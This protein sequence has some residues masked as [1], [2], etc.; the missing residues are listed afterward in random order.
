MTTQ[1]VNQNVCHYNKFGYCKHKEACRKQHIFELCENPSCDLKTC[2]LRH[3]RNCKWHREL[4]RCKFDPC[5]FKHEGNSFENYRKENEE[6]KPKLAEVDR[7]LKALEE[8]EIQT[9]ATIEKLKMINEQSENQNSMYEN[10][11]E[12]LNEMEGKDIQINNLLEKV[13]L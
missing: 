1:S 11:M 2:I 7:S 3:P 6:I 13:R 5:P 8:K 12:R 10:V 4:G 9:N